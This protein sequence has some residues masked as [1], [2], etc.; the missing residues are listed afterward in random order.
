ML[1]Y[2]AFRM[3]TF[4]VTFNFSLVYEIEKE[5]EFKVRVNTHYSIT[6]FVSMLRTSIEYDLKCRSSFLTSSQI[7]KFPSLT[8]KPSI[9]KKSRK[10]STQHYLRC[11]SFRI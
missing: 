9:S 10:R 4:C 3:T 5:E 8:K 11:A 1:L 7:S 6:A 2:F